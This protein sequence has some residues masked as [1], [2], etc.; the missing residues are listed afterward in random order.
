[1]YKKKI[2]IAKP[3]RKPSGLSSAK[4]S[5]RRKGLGVMSDFEQKLYKRGK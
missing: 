1:M 3:K 2:T 5:K 4:G